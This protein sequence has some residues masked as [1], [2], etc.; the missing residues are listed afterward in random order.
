MD[1]TQ[2]L[3]VALIVRRVGKKLQLPIYTAATCGDLVVAFQTT[4]SRALVRTGQ[5]MST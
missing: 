3:P 4:A 2:L 5:E 1:K